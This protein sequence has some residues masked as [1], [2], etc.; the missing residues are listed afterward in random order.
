MRRIRQ[1]LST[2]E[3]ES[4]SNSSYEKIGGRTYADKKNSS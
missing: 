4:A 2:S 1:L 3:E